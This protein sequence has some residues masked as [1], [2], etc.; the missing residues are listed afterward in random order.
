MNMNEDARSSNAESRVQRW[1]DAY[2]WATDDDMP[3]HPLREAWERLEKICEC[4]V[5]DEIVLIW[6]GAR[7]LE[8]FLV[9]YARRFM[10]FD[11]FEECDAAFFWR[12]VA[13][14]VGVHLDTFD[15]LY[16]R[17]LLRELA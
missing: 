12:V 1:F 10:E 8:D 5:D 3:K 7:T 11:D 6:R 13:L 17:N 9:K 14:E 2:D 16:N 15:L 4:E